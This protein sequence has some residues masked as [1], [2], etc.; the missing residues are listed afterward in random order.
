MENF[1]TYQWIYLRTGFRSSSKL[2]LRVGVRF[3]SIFLSG[4][5]LYL[6]ATVNSLCPNWTKILNLLNQDR[7]TACLPVSPAQVE[8][9]YSHTTL[10]EQ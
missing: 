3:R 4:C 9:V 6:G 5:E 10:I 8:E 2:S 7:W 1:K